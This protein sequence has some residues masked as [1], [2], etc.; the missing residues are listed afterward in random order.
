MNILPEICN[1]W[2]DKNR[3]LEKKKKCRQRLPE[4]KIKAGTLG[5][6]NPFP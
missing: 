5:E 1:F 3:E 2:H 6:Q 4:L